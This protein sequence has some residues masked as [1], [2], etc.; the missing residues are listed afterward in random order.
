MD[1]PRAP[2]ALGGVAAI[3]TAGDLR[4]GLGLDEPPPGWKIADPKRVKADP[5]ALLAG[6][7]V[8]LARRVRLR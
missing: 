3:T 4:L 1:Y 2:D 7:P 6:K 8:A 5:V